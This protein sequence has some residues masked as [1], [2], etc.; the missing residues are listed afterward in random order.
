MDLILKAV[1]ALYVSL[2]KFS[3]YDNMEK[4]LNDVTYETIYKLMELMDGLVNN[5]I[6]GEIIS[7][8]SGNSINAGV[9]LHDYCDEYLNCSDI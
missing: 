3:K 4:L 5:S 7:L 2:L 1:M 6:R 9:E 8:P